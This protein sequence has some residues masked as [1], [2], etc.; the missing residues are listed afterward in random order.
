MAWSPESR[1]SKHNSTRRCTEPG[2]QAGRL[3]RKAR[4]CGQGE[5]PDG[6]ILVLR[7]SRRADRARRLLGAVASRQARCHGDGPR[8]IR[9]KSSRPTCRVLLS[10]ASASSDPGMVLVL[11]LATLEPDT[12]VMDAR[13]PELGGTTRVL[14]TAP[15]SIVHARVRVEISGRSRKSRWSPIPPG[16]QSAPASTRS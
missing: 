8:P 15:S 1:T 2:P 12:V 5:G 6:A 14:I 11:K 16:C 9:S 3:H 10:S 7:R 13:T 4:G